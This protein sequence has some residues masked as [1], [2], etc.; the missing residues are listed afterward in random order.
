VPTPVTGARPLPADPLTLV[1]TLI[2]DDLR[3]CPPA[4]FGTVLGV[5]RAA[6][7]VDRPAPDGLLVVA[8]DDVGG[9]PGGILVGGIDDLRETGLRA[10]MTVVPA[11]HGAAIAVPEASVTI[12]LSRAEPWSPTLPAPARF[13]STADIAAVA[14]A[15]RRVAVS[16]APTAGLAPMLTGSPGSED[17]WLVRARAVIGAQL[18]ALGRGDT[19]AALEPT[20]DVIGL[21]IGLTPSGDDYLVGL[22]AGLDA[23]HDPA[24]FGLAEAIGRQ[25]PA[26][27]TA[28]SAASLR[29]ATRGAFSERL[30]D[31]LVA[32]ARGRLDDLES[33]IRRAMAYGAT[34]GSDTLVGLLAALDLAAG[35]STRRQIAR[36][37]TVAA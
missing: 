10:G 18:A 1:A 2:A 15:A 7:Y 11:P 24:R 5:H 36:V 12:D 30:H 17:P 31:L 21:G 4:V 25:A 19:A 28:I 27:S 37:R 22:L 34:S 20:V 6:I 32:L 35:R 13:R 33:P 29:H 16:M 9:V 23:T 14:A 26:R 3:E 8:I